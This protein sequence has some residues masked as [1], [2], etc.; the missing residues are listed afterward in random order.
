MA[1]KRKPIRLQKRRL[2]KLAKL[3]EADAKNKKGVKFD[4][5]V[6]GRSSDYQEFRKHPDVK[7]DCGTTACAMGL[8][9][10]SGAFKKE[11]LSFDIYLNTNQITTKFK[12]RFIGYD[13]AA[14]KLF[15]ISMDQ[16]HYL[17]S[18]YTYLSSKTQGAAAERH[19]IRR[20]K[21]VV[22]GKKI[23]VKHY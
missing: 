20:I 22:E 23:V 19:V 16:A 2:L 5:Y 1:R 21:N 3:L 8:A 6:V 9:A 12:G 7:M 13:E 17:F 11:G 15:G 14:V 18:P 10:I 4:L